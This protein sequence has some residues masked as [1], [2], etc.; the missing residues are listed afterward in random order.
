MAE[1]E[2]KAEERLNCRMGKGMSIVDTGYD[3]PWAMY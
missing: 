2:L 3:I 1:Y